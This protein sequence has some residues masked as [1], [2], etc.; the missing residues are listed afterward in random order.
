[1][2][3]I[4]FVQNITLNLALSCYGVL[5]N[6]LI[7]ISVKSNCQCPHLIFNGWIWHHLKDALNAFICGASCWSKQFPFT[8]FATFCSPISMRNRFHASNALLWTQTRLG[9]EII[10]LDSEIILNM[11]KKKKKKHVCNQWGLVKSIIY[12]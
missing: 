3:V 1:M 4:F 2:T 7:F 12:L 5:F 10:F 11:V 9:Y 6:S 8:H